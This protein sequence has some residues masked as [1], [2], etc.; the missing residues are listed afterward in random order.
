MLPADKAACHPP[1]GARIAPV[2]FAAEPNVSQAIVIR[3]LD[4]DWSTSNGMGITVDLLEYQFPD[5]DNAP[6][7]SNW[8]MIRVRAV[9]PRGE[10]TSIEPSLLTYEVAT[11]ADWLDCVAGKDRMGPP[12]SLSFTEPNLRFDTTEGQDGEEMLRVSFEL[13]SRPPWMPASVDPGDPAWLEF[14]TGE[15]DLHGAATRLREQLTRF[16]QRSER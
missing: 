2:D 4:M 5:L 10:W 14:P 3:N 16:P 11:L 7:D 6:Y 15:V 1:G 13:E 8:L 9:H 12:S